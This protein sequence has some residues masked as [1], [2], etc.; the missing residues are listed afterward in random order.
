MTVKHNMG[1]SFAGFPD[2]QAWAKANGC[3]FNNTH[4]HTMTCHNDAA[5]SRRF[6]MH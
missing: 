5:D 3:P 1:P 2:L 6:Y 4:T